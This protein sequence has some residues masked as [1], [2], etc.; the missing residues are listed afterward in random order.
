[1]PA[2]PRLPH[3]PDLPALAR[4][5][6][7]T[8]VNAV[9][10]LRHGGFKTG[11]EYS[12]YD[13]VHS[14]P[15]Y[16]LRRYFPDDVPF[17]A[18]VMLL[19]HPL[20]ITGDFWDIAPKT[21]AVAALHAMGIDVWTID[22]GRP[23]TEPGGLERTLTDHAMAL[24]EAVDEV[25]TAT[26]RDIVLGGQS[27]GGMFTYQVAAWRR[28]EGIDSLVTF[29]APVDQRAPL[30][31][32]MSPHT[33]AVLARAYLDSGLARR[34]SIPGWA[35]R[36][37]TQM[38]TPIGVTR[39][40]L[41]YY[42]NLHDRERLI[43]RERLRMYLDG[44]G[45]TAYS[46][47]AF[48]E[49]LEQFMVHNRMLEGGFIFRDRLV[50]L[51]DI[52]IPVLT[53]VGLSDSL[54]TPPSV[55]GIRRAAPRAAVY[56]LTI[57]SGHFGII[58][59]VTAS[60]LTWPNV[61][62][63]IHW[64]AGNGS[65]PEAIV[66]AEDIDDWKPADSGTVRR[67][68]GWTGDT[69]VAV[70]AR[71]ASSLS[72]AVKGAEDLARYGV[73]KVPALREVGDFRPRPHLSLGMLLDEAASRDAES[74]V[75]AFGDRVI[76]HGRFKHRVDSIVKG[77]L[78]LGMRPGDRIGVLMSSRPSAFSLV[79]AINRLGATAV[80]LRPEGDLPTEVRL[81]K[82]IWLVSDPEN[83][84]EEAVPGAQWCVLGVSSASRELPAHVID[85]EQIDPSRTRVPSWYRPNA[86][87]ASDVAFVL[88]A[89]QGAAATRDITISNRRWAL[90]A[91]AGS[92]AAGLKDTDTVYSVTPLYH[93]SAILH[94][95]AGAIASGARLAL[96]S[97]T[98]PDTF[99]DEVRRYGA[100]HISY[101]WTSLQAVV[102]GPVH[103]SEQD[104]P[105]RVFMGSGMPPGLWR[106]VEERFPT[107]R[108]VEVFASARGD[109][110]LANG[111]GT[112]VGSV[113]RSLPNTPE[114][115]VVEYAL[116]SRRIVPG[117]DGFARETRPDKVGMLVV[118][119]DVTAGGGDALLRNLFAADDRW[120]DTGDLF[121]RDAD[122]DH[123][124]VDSISD[125]IWTAAGPVPPSVVSQ[126]LEKLPS[127]A[128]AA[129][130]GV[131]SDVDGAE[132]VVGAVDPLDGFRLGGA[133]LDRALQVLPRPQ[134]PAYVVATAI[135]L[136]A[137]SRPR[138]GP[139]RD[140]GVPQPR[141]GLRVWRLSDGERYERLR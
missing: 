125:L 40:K 32:P 5:V 66:P 70:T 60:R 118:R 13:V 131:P 49:L 20:M 103:P 36:T 7:A 21:S 22:F 35:M 11:E 83:A 89:G 50:S 121:R 12:P 132:L 116:A 105:V 135:P 8:A 48:A 76:R 74:V 75:Y 46:G 96:A 27:Q 91:A 84:R 106:R 45:W 2:F 86:G 19:V 104:H 42:L 85:M 90:S 24:S 72:H 138:V 17:D 101:T 95:M 69:G 81:G 62:G 26:G 141:R 33:A 78:G 88:F 18:P 29:G 1:M 47:P 110:I 58:G 99:W 4:R 140:A 67:L 79:A 115:R 127:V 59:G 9:D 102:D 61:G 119:Q 130:Y 57:N 87:Q 43:P 55:R 123:W 15:L 51:A 16:K 54:A 120:L 28:G 25:R 34:I 37:G 82:V 63:W 14:H 52:D 93:S 30:G 114:V 56:E 109:A 44:A 122:G 108:V 111:T 100:T 73:E 6:G 31:V 39:G 23:E 126:A 133:D 136:T 92:R 64:R 129:A 137:W 134:R 71:A 112:K 10:V 65:L 41:Q 94:S 68:V 97:D 38:I 77:M 124:F 139:L 113:G 3:V 80:M 107:T 117:G 53:V 128:L 98:D